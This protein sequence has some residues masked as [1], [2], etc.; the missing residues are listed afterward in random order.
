MRSSQAKDSKWKKKKHTQIFYFFSTAAKVPLQQRST[1]SSIVYVYAL[2]TNQNALYTMSTENRSKTL[3]RAVFRIFQNHCVSNS[4]EMN[5]NKQRL[6]LPWNLFHLPKP[7]RKK[8]I[9]KTVINCSIMIFELEG[10]FCFYKIDMCARWRLLG[11]SSA[12]AILLHLSRLYDINFPQLHALKIESLPRW[13]RNDESLV[14]RL[15][16]GIF[17]YEEHQMR[18][19]NSSKVPKNHRPN[20]TDTHTHTPNLSGFRRFL[21]L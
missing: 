14:F 6:K 9:V 13:M 11:K 10:F 21:L 5:G 20:S 4:I 7:K 1:V 8:H 3:Q 19:I 17:L 12:H 16:C 15:L 18:A 2:H